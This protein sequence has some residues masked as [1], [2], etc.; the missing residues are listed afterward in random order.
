GAPC[1]ICDAPVKRNELGFEIEYTLDGGAGE[2]NYH[3]HLGCYSALEFESRNFEP[4]QRP[5]GASDQVQAAAAFLSGAR[6]SE[7]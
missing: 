4:A 3:V 5:A 6:R 1:M 7:I 2:S